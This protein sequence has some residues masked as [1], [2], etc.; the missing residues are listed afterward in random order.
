ME[1]A[2]EAENVPKN[3]LEPFIQVYRF[4]APLEP[5]IRAFRRLALSHFLYEELCIMEKGVSDIEVIDSVSRKRLTGSVAFRVRRVRGSL[6]PEESFSLERRLNARAKDVGLLVDLENPRNLIEVIVSGSF[7]LIGRRIC[8]SDRRK[9]FSRSGGT[10]PFFHPSSLKAE[11]ARAML[12]LARVRRGSI[13]LDPFSG[14]GTILVEA[15]ELQAIPVGLEIDPA[16]AYP[17]IRNYKWFGAVG[18]CQ[19]LGDARC[20]PLRSVDAIVTDPPYGRRAS[21]HGLDSLKVYE[22]FIK[23]AAGVLRKSGRMVL[24]APSEM[25]VE[26]FIESNGLMIT[27]TYFME[28]HSSLTRKLL[29]AKS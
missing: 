22:E 24:L 1:G 4:E 6:T 25:P 18:V 8:S 20:M 29:V 5:A 10:R 17:S 26:D 21:T 23:N 7:L 2:L 9:V 28:V 11:L 12:N 27:E 15:Y 19:I 16:M 14:T 13:V 3:V